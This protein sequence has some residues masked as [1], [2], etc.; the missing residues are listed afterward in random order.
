MNKLFASL[1]GNLTLFIEGLFYLILLGLNIFI[2]YNLYQ[3]I[4]LDIR[5]V[6]PVVGEIK[7]FKITSLNS[8]GLKIFEEDQEGRK[9]Y[10]EG[11]DESYTKRWENFT[12]PVDPFLR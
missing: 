11:L 9:F 12:N 5:P 4:I 1:K 6:V 10:I 2:G 8:A 3:N 7:L